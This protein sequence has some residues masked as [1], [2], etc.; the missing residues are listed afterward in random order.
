MR[1]L[2]FGRGEL[3]SAVRPGLE[4]SLKVARL[5]ASGLRDFGE[6]HRADLHAIMEGEG[7]LIPPRSL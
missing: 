1:R 5:K 6:H 3:S 2:V 4:A 7:K